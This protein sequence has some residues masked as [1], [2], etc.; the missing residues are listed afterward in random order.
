MHALRFTTDRPMDTFPR[1]LDQLRR[2]GF[3]LHRAVIADAMTERARVRFMFSGGKAGAA[4]TLRDR[5]AGMPGVV[6]ASLCSLA[7]DAAEAA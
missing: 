1:A 5:V 6:D 3:D 2:M 4:A 7:R